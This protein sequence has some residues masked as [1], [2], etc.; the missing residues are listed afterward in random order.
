MVLGAGLL[1]R[2]IFFSRGLYRR[3]YLKQEKKK[4]NGKKNSKEVFILRLLR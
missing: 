1:S 3:E 2:K 4:K